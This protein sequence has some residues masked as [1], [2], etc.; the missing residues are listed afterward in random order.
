MDVHSNHIR[1]KNMR[2]IK[3]SGTKL[4]NLL[5]KELWLRGVRYR[6][7][8]TGVYGKPDFTLRGLKIAIFVDGEFFHG[9][10]WTIEKYRIG[11][12]RDF[13]WPK[14]EAN[15]LR[16]AAVNAELE[17]RGWITLR[18]WARTLRENLRSCVD[19]IEETIAQRRNEIKVPKST[20]GS[21]GQSQRQG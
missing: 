4:E 11:T 9:F 16:D 15:M 10:N 8:D 3:S 2:A 12:R 5:A 20:R 6:R 18:Y 1:S 13:W 14:I 17:A 19:E 7:N 21:A